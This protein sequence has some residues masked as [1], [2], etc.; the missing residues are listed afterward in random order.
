MCRRPLGDDDVSV[1][2]HRVSARTRVATVDIEQALAEP[3]SRFVRSD[4]EAI[5]A[6]DGGVYVGWTARHVL[7]LATAHLRILR[8][9]LVAAGRDPA[10]FPL[11]FELVQNA[12]WASTTASDA[13]LEAVYNWPLSKTFQRFIDEATSIAERGHEE[14]LDW[15]LEQAS[16][17]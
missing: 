10:A 12:E 11:A 17:K 1:A 16:R 9:D 15:V 2:I 6:A 8:A 13:D 4:W 14:T 7:G 3:N 5:Q